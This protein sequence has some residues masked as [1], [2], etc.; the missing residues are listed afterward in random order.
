MPEPLKQLYNK[1]LIDSLCNQIEQIY[2]KFDSTQFKKTIFDEAWQQKEL[3]QRM[4]HISEVLHKYLPSHYK[5]ALE[6][7]KPVSSHF[8]GFQYMFFPDYVELYG[9]KNYQASISALEHF[10]PFS[11]SEFAVRPFIKKYQSKMMAQME[12]WAQSDNYH[13]RRLASEGCRPRLPWAMAL[14]EFKQNP[15]P[16]FKILA[17]L[18][19]DESEYVRRSVANNLNDI[20]KDNPQGVIEVA[21]KWLGKNTAT[22]WLL[23]HAC[24]SLLKQ[25]QTEVLT[26]FGFQAPNHVNIINFKVQESVSIGEKLAFSFTLKTTARKLG[27]LRIEYAIYF[28]RLNGKTSNKVFKISESYYVVTKKEFLKYHS[29]K[30]ISTRKYYP[31]SHKLSIIVNGEQIAT[32]SFELT[33]KISTS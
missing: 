17:H 16:I 14:P 21:K 18:M 12:K 19:E 6:I 29:F 1:A 30:I 32:S 28:V 20:S 7:L 11:S 15:E 31:G 5:T 3:K 33:K 8:K 27:K 22:D 9:L 23:K 24:R 4:R 2:A 26:L 13:I 25:G 10:T